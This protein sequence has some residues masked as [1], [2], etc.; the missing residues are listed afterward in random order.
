MHRTVC[1]ALSGLCCASVVLSMDLHARILVELRWSASGTAPRTHC[2][3]PSWKFYMLSTHSSRVTHRCNYPLAHVVLDTMSLGT[4]VIV[5]WS[6]INLLT[7]SDKLVR[8]MY[9]VE[10]PSQAMIS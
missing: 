1:S 6:V 10:R 8:T 2:S 3:R 9:A 4:S 5:H 7:Q